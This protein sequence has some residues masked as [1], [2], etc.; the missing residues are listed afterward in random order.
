MDARDTVFSLPAGAERLPETFARLREAGPVV[1]VELPG[2]VRVWAVL[3]HAAVREVL[4]G[5]NTRFGKHS[6]HWVALR[7]GAIPPDWPLLALVRGEHMLMRDGGEHRRL[8]SLVAQDFTPTRVQALRPRITQIVE[9]LIAGVIAHGA[10]GRPVDL[11]ALF[12]Q[13]LPVAVISELLG[14][15]AGERAQLRGWTQTLFSHT[16]TAEQTHR[17]AGEFLGY[18]NTLVD[19]KRH[20]PGA[21]LTSAMIRSLDHDQLSLRELIDCL[22][23]LV[24]AGHETTVHLLGHAIVNLLAHSDQL[25]LALA[26][27]RWPEVTEEALR[28][29]PPVHSSGFR[30]PLAPTQLAGVPLATGDALL[31]CI[32][33]AATDP[34][35]HGADATRFDITRHQRGHL[36]F[37]H[38]PHFCLGAPLARLEAHIALPALFHRLPSMKATVAFDDI[39]YSPSFLT[40]GPLSLPVTLNHPT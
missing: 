9:E 6:S 4:E 21:D 39:P 19:H 27:N 1:R 22:Y 17:A 10:D 31:L 37:G 38:G 36:A 7:E 11:I 33:G 34:T 15:P 5:D 23:L 29:T 25:D 3:T 30:Y 16:S 13:P 28:L 18:L 14:I 26:E 2:G 8:R 24:I 20:H 32:A 12:A 35:Y 40:Y